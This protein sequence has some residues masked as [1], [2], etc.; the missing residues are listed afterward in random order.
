MTA[1]GERTTFRLEEIAASELTQPELREIAASLFLLD[2][3]PDDADVTEIGDVLALIDTTEPFVQH[4]V[5]AY[6][7]IVD[8]FDGQAEVVVDTTP[9]AACVYVSWADSDPSR[10]YLY[11]RCDLTTV[12]GGDL[13]ADALHRAIDD[14]LNDPEAWEERE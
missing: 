6:R 7:V 3:L 13:F 2:G 1:T 8:R 10:G 4:P 14:F 9:D 12:E 11:E 5:L